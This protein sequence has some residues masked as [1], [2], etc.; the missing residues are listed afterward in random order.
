MDGRPNGND[1]PTGACASAECLAQSPKSQVSPRL[2]QLSATLLGVAVPLL[3]RA[4][5]PTSVPFY[6]KCVGG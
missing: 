3:P 1:L 2:V 5:P 6:A 4:A